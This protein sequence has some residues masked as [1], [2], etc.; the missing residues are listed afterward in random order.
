MKNL[1]QTINDIVNETEIFDIQEFIF[2]AEFK[3]YHLSVINEV[4]NL[5]LFNCRIIYYNKYKYQK[6]FYRLTNEEKST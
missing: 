1:K 5:S 2:L 4:L 6:K 3:K